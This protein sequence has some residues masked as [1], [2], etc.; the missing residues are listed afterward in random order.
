[1]LTEGHKYI[2]AMAYGKFQLWKNNSCIVRPDIGVYSYGGRLYRG[3]TMQQ[4]TIK[5]LTTLPQGERGVCINPISLPTFCEQRAEKWSRMKTF[6]HDRRGRCRVLAIR[7]F[8][9]ALNEKFGLDE[10][11]A[12]AAIYDTLDLMR[13]KFNAEE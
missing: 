11:Q 6:I 12:Q 10:G 5:E 2:R 7:S 1:M 8:R 9:V 4:T 13:L 3:D